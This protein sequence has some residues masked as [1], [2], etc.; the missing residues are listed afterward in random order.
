MKHIQQN[1]TENFPN[2]EEEK[3][4]QIQGAFITPNRQGQK[5]THNIVEKS[6]LYRARKEY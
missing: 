4:I 1:N 6:Y 5:R 2:L 3:E